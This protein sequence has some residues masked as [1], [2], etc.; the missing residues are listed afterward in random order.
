MSEAQVDVGA[1]LS[2]PGRGDALRSVNPRRV[3]LLV[4]PF[5]TAAV[6]AL[7][8]RASPEIS[9]GT[10]SDRFADLTGLDQVSGVATSTNGLELGTESAILSLSVDDLASGTLEG[11]AAGPPLAAIR[12]DVAGF[13]VAHVLNSS[14]A[15]GQGSSLGITG[16]DVLHV[17]WYATNLVPA[18]V[19]TSRSAD[20]GATWTAPVKMP[21]GAAAARYAPSLSVGPTGRLH[22]AWYEIG[23]TQNGVYYAWSADQGQNW[24]T[25]TVNAGANQTFPRIVADSAQTAH[26]VWIWDEGDNNPTAPGIYYAASRNWGVRTKI[27]HAT[28]PGVMDRP[29]LV[30]RGTKLYAAW[31]D[32]R[33]G[34][35]AVYVA[36]SLDGGLTWSAEVPPSTWASDPSLQPAQD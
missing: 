28:T 34:Q 18:N 9:D 1:S 12:L 6:L 23:S 24:A 27:S 17:A 14:T 32:T 7:A 20:L 21:G 5:L 31:A 13:S 22:V 29:A 8:V 10:W 19:L 15:G 4:V 2:S 25:A 33:T 11:V 35:F 16:E 36:H 30:V 26:V 3:F